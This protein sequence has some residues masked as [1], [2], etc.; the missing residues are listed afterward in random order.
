MN[1]KDYLEE[2]RKGLKALPK[3]EREDILHD[4]EEH[5][6]MGKKKKRTEAEIAKSLG[7]PKDIVKQV[8]AEQ[9][10]NKAEKG[11]KPEDILR[12]VL[13]SLGLGFLNL[14]FILGPFIVLVAIIIS[15]YAVGISIIASGIAVAFSSLLLPIFSITGLGFVSGLGLVFIGIGLIALGVLFIIGTGY[16]T[17]GFA[18][19]TTKYL[20]FNINIIKGGDDK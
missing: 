14:I 6:R 19:L 5:F 10:I 7:K 15:F 9:A 12:A 11:K 1:R 8:K 3:E 17:K 16:L 20:R 2:L 18:W 4:Y 13:A